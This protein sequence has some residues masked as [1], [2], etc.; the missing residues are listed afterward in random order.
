MLGG[1][2]AKPEIQKVEISTLEIPKRG[3]EEKYEKQQ[4]FIC[5]TKHDSSST[6]DSSLAKAKFI[7]GEARTQFTR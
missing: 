6:N 4:K 5:H 7:G 1:S 3:T 2:A